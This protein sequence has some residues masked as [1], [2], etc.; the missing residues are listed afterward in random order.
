M[1][2]TLH[3]SHAESRPTIGGFFMSMVVARMQKMKAENLIGLGNH[4][5]RKTANH[6]NQE[7]DVTRS[8]LNYDLVDRTNNY[9]TDIQ[10]FI[11]ETKASSRAVRKDAVLVSE[12]IITSDT[13][14]FN[15]LDEKQT[16]TFFEVAKNYFAKNYG[17]E[18]IRYAQVHVD[19]RTPHMHLGIVPFTEDKRLSSKTIFN[20][21]ALKNIQEELP[22]ELKKQGFAIERGEQGSTRSHM[23]VQEFKDY[24]ETMTKHS[25][26]TKEVDG[27][28]R[29]YQTYQAVMDTVKD[30]NV[31]TEPLLEKRGLLKREEI[32]T[33]KVIISKKDFET[34]HEAYR[35]VPVLKKEVRAAKRAEQAQAEE[36]MQIKAQ[37]DELK[38]ENKQLQKMVAGAKKML[39][40]LD[41][42][43]E[44]H[45]GISFKEALAEDQDKH[46]EKKTPESEKKGPQGPSL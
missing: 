41:D 25:Q 13:D 34:L 30:I 35:Y 20:R 11:N 22:D 19:E 6:S 33:D 5:Q 29:D 27:L 1:C 36:K 8:H 16:R 38:K 31:P 32:E 15:T 43:L 23:A 14:F 2:Y 24:K 17:E 9:K 37:R 7:I 21:Q 39:L 28:E 44:K 26:L 42:Y 45:L 4:N 3:G 12:W 40:K 10:T 46:R 18:N